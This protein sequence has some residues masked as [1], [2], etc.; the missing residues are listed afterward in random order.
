[1]STPETDNATIAFYDANAR[2][3]AEASHETRDEKQ[4]ARFCDLVR[5][6]GTV[7][8]LGSGNG[9]ASAA[10]RDAGFN[11]HPIDG[12]TGLARE[13]KSRFDL[14]VTVMPF[15]EF[16][17]R[18]AYDGIWAAWSLHHAKRA[19]FPSLLARVVGALRSDGVLYLA[20]KGG[21]GEKRD[22][23]DRLYAYY[24]TD[25]L[26]AELTTNGMEM[27]D[28]QTFDG[29]GFDGSRTPMHMI[30]ARRKCSAFQAA[31]AGGQIT[32]NA[33]QMNAAPTIPTPASAMRASPVKRDAT[34]AAESTSW[35]MPAA[36]APESN[37]PRPGRNALT[38]RATPLFMIQTHTCP[39]RHH[40]IAL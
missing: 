22:S 39:T 27:L 25:E 7:C 24:S 26:K 17:A 33:D 10:L 35:I 4:L 15:E 16:A 32:I 11:V 9:W 20:M 29:D 8:D 21:S 37:V 2:D 5:A 6:G 3:Y 14:D 34:P 30:L 13:A 38:S 23:L 1:M 40:R 28:C 18:D 31:G 12:S 19:S 36:A